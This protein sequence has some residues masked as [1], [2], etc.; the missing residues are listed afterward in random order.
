MAGGWCEW[1]GGVSPVE[2]GTWIYVKLR[3][4]APD[5][6]LWEEPILAEEV[7]W[8]SGLG[9]DDVVAYRVLED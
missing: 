6:D 7:D 4:D 5:S 2:E 1:T 8:R 3:G 9:V